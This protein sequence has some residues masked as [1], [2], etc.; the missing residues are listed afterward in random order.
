M[1]TLRTIRSY[2][3]ESF[4]AGRDGRTSLR[5]LVP[6]CIG[7]AVVIGGLLYVSKYGLRVRTAVIREGSAAIA[8]MVTA[9]EH[10]DNL[11]WTEAG[12][13]FVLAQQAFESAGDRLNAFGPSLVN[14]LS[15]VPGL[16]SLGAGQDIIEAGKL[17][18]GAGAS[19]SNVL[20]ELS[21]EQRRA[22]G[23]E[24]L[25]VGAVLTAFDA[26]LEQAD[27]DV[28]RALELLNGIDAAVIPD[29]QREQWRSSGGSSVRIG[30]G[31]TWSSSRIPASSVR[32][33]ASRERTGS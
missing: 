16:G 28:S 1:R 18:S 21:D 25:P 32:P 30:R 5:S 24:G 26:K 17:L 31:A 2:P 3:P 23:A 27:R 19:L 13:D 20:G 10:A 6:W 11:S 22:S 29:A 8:H 15:R 14:L 9:K 33:A 7:A 4:P 12:E